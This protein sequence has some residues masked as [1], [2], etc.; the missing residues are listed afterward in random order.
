MGAKP[1]AME[2]A[3]ALTVSSVRTGLR[4]AFPRLRYGEKMLLWKG[5]KAVE[6]PLAMT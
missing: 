3:A 1:Q 2:P 4:M 5:I 6:S